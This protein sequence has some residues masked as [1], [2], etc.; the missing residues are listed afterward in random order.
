VDIGLAADVGILQ[1]IH[2]LTGNDSWARELA[3]TGRDASATE[4]QKYGLMKSKITNYNRRISFTGVGFTRAVPGGSSG[5]G[6][7]NRFKKS[8][9]CTGKQNGHELRTLAWS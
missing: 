4:A 7:T 8:Y 6:P 1:R 5:L 9:S 3:F 2:V